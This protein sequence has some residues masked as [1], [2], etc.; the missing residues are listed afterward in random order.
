MID[1]GSRHNRFRR[2]TRAFKLASTAHFNTGAQAGA[3]EIRGAV[4]QVRSD[5]S[6]LSSYLK[7]REGPAYLHGAQGAF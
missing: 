5:T 6:V 1:A 3:R 2:M 7:Y 4:G